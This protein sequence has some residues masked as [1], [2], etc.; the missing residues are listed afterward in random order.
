MG[1]VGGVVVGVVVGAVVGLVVAAVVGTVV[2][3]TVG[4]EVVPVVGVGAVGEVVVCALVGLSVGTTTGKSVGRIV[5]PG[6]VANVPAGPVDGCVVGLSA[7]F[8]AGT[9]AGFV[10]F[11]VGLPE[12]VSVGS[13]IS[14]V[15]DASVLFVV[16][17]WADTAVEG[18]MVS[19]VGAGVGSAEGATE[20]TTIAGA[21]E[22]VA[23]ES[24]CICGLFLSG[25]SQI[26]PIT[27]KIPTTAKSHRR[28]FFSG[29][30]ISFSAKGFMQ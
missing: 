22:A 26:N 14:S 20:G 1:A 17:G 24:S 19:P 29:G 2:G 5:E 3:I 13:A 4:A 8:V 16:T 30:M 10:M 28:S 18:A 21:D 23:W 7:G 27:S 12:T 9:V 15:G 11:T 6:L 25:N